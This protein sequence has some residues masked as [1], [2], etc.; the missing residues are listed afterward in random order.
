[1]RCQALYRGGGPGKLRRS[2]NAEACQVRKI[3]MSDKAKALAT[4]EAVL[5]ASSE[6]P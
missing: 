5:A 1:L 3:P 4:I 6:K 2:A